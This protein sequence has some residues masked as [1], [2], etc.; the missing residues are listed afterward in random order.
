MTT[1]MFVITWIL[2]GFTCM[3]LAEIIT[4]TQ[5]LTYGT[6]LRC[7]IIG[8]FAG[9]FAI[10]ASIIVAIMHSIVNIFI[11]INQSKFWNKRVFKPREKTFMEEL[12]IIIKNGRK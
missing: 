4:S 1:L 3:L 8:M 12:S 2:S 10:I 11:Y 5:Y 9:Y 7:F 6:V